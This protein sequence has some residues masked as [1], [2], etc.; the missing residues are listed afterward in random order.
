MTEPLIGVAAFDV[1]SPMAAGTLLKPV[2]GSGAWIVAMV[3]TRPHA[4][5]DLL[6]TRSDEALAAIEWSDVLQALAAHPRVGDRPQGDGLEATWSRQEQSG[7]A[8][9]AT[10]VAEA[11]RAGNVEYEERFGHVFLICATGRTSEQ[12]LA[13]LSERLDNDEDTEREVVRRELT[14]IVRLRLSKTFE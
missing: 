14:E 9:A 3:A 1:L 8:G 12:M 2:C 7:T 6:M 11:L 10:D 4:T 5:M 13:A